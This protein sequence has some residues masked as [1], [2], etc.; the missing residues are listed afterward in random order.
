MRTALLFALFL[1]HAT[2]LSAQQ[3]QTRPLAE[4]ID[5]RDP[6]W[7][8]VQGMIA[9]AKNKVQLLPKTA[10]RADNALLAAQVTTRSPMGAI[11]YE[12]GG[13]LVDNGWLRILGSGSPVLERDLIGWN[14]NKQAGIL[15]IADD[16]LG[17]F[18]AL[19]GGG[20]GQL[21]L[22]K[23]YYL[24][25]TT[26]EW[27]PL[28]MGYSEFLAFCFSGDLS[29]FYDGMRWKGWQHEIAALNGNQ[30]IGCYPF[31]FADEGKN[32][33]KVQRR[34]VSIQELW[35]FSNDMRQQMGIR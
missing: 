14:K 19:N 21:T 4:L 35:T 34:P 29:K 5:A 31:L 11:I 27:T 1:L 15:L 26:L 7:P 2:C 13:I 6:G 25:P 16:A 8:V 22:G 10:T 17:G 28:D 12:T 32:I 9:A 18:F 30:G 33:N 24:S 23:V 20:F 3:K